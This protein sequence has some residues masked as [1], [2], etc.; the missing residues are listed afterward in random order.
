MAGADNNA[1]SVKV[2][3]VVATVGVDAVATAMGRSVKDSRAGA[4]TAPSIAMA[5]ISV[6]VAVAVEVVVAGKEEVISINGVISVDADVEI[7]AAADCT[8]IGA[9]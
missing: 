2:T 8:T 6:K 7:G 1:L 4:V 3:V 5:V 9:C